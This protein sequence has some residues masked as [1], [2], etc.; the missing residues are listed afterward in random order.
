MRLVK[1]QAAVTVLVAAAVTMVPMQ[2]ASAVTNPYKPEAVCG[3]GFKKVPGST[4]PMKSGYP[5]GV[6][7][8]LHLLYN[9]ETG[10][11]C[12]VAMK[13]TSLGTATTVQVA[14]EV[15][16][17]GS[18]GRGYNQAMQGKYKYYG[19]PIRLKSD[20]KCV[21]YSGMIYSTDGAMPAYAEGTSGCEGRQT[22]GFPGSTLPGA[23]P[24]GTGTL[25][26]GE[27]PSLPGLVPPA[28]G[29]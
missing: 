15:D 14:L 21:K 5:G 19:G 24:G 10:Q 13:A 3:S 18:G 9:A 11:H 8:Y 23:L 25:A 27:V 29:V 26:P 7:G 6:V 16:S 17:D 28:L 4:R 12:A 20:G 2:T 22:W 1:K